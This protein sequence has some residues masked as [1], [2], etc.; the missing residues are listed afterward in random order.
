MSGGLTLWESF[1]T[2]MSGLFSLA[3]RTVFATAP[4]LGAVASSLRMGA[5][6]KAPTGLPHVDVIG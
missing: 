3:V 5:K 4:K 1:F 6:R 2:I